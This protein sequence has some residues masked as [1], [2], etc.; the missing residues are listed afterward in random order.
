M[1]LANLQSGLGA[2][3]QDFS[4]AQISGLGTLG[5]QQQ[6]QSQAILDAQ[7]QASQMAVDDPRRRLSMLGA[8]ITQ[9]VPGAGAVTLSPET[10]APQASPLTTALGLGLAGA[11]IY[12]RIFGGRK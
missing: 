10:I 4:R 12:G 9:L 5:A 1:G 3:A 7:R 8:G 2:R 6:A 11:D